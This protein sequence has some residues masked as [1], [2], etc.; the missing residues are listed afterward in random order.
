MAPTESPGTANDKRLRDRLR[1]SPEARLGWLLDFARA[2]APA[3][4]A[5]FRKTWE[6]LFFLQQTRTGVFFGDHPTS[7]ARR[8]AVLHA[9]EHLR[10]L[11][12]E[13]AH[14][15]Q[16]LF[17]A[18]DTFWSF[19]PPNPRR[20]GARVS[21]RIARANDQDI[22][23]KQLPAAV[24]F[25][26]LDLLDEVGADRLKACPLVGSHGPCGKIFLAHGRKKFCT[27]QHAQKASF[28]AYLTRGGDT[29]RKAARR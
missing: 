9:H 26:A 29:A 14:G 22:V 12:V 28:Q 10:E 2:E 27:P 19:T 11:F 21:A 7:P 25:K 23:P 8:S 16:F 24:V 15:R 20:A 18:P 5:N 13:L 1:R 4:E 17:H 3:S 6:I